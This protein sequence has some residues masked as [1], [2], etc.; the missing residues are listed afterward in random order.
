[1]MEEMED[2]QPCRILCTYMQLYE[3]NAFPKHY[4]K[5][6][7]CCNNFDLHN[8]LIIQKSKE[9]GFRCV[10]YTSLP[11]QV[12]RHA[13]KSKGVIQFTHSYYSFSYE[14]PS[15]YTYTYTV[16]HSIGMYIQTMH[17]IKPACMT[18]FS[19]E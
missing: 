15:R 2:F 6:Q 18:N 7:S 8:P 10:Y 5:Y 19:Q 11:A 14:T 17:E 13:Y 1:M 4:H 9:R 12:C 3:N 16:I